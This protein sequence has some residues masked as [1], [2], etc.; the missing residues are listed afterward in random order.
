MTPKEMYQWAYIKS[1]HTN[2]CKKYIFVQLNEITKTVLYEVSKKGYCSYSDFHQLFEFFDYQN[3]QNE[4]LEFCELKKEF[5]PNKRYSS[6]VFIR[7]FFKC[8]K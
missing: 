1:K 7:K 8:F 4:F 5:N 2:S 3:R 6:K